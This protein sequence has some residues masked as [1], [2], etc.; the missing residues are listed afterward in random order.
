MTHNA[1]A[2]SNPLDYILAL[3]L[4]LAGLHLRA[5]G[6][7]G[8]DHVAAGYALLVDSLAHR[9]LVR[10][11]CATLAIRAL[12][13][14]LDE[15]SATNTSALAREMARAEALT[16]LRAMLDGSP[17]PDPKAALTAAWVRWRAVPSADEAV[18]LCH[19]ALR[20]G[21]TYVDGP[22]ACQI[23]DALGQRLA[24]ELGRG[25]LLG[26]DVAPGPVAATSG[27]PADARRAPRARA[28][29]V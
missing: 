29:V 14:A 2:P 16:A 9:G 25:D 12:L 22:G 10:G 20:V 7:H 4:S 28:E 24:R 17:P 1:T 26:E 8:R 6:V 23:G 13:F 5:A 21:A 3:S 19:A 11:R 18:G 27:A 15:V